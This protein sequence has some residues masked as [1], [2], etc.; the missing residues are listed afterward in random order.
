MALSEARKKANKKWDSE[1]LATFTIKIRK[2]KA[3]LFRQAAAADGKT[4][5]EILRKCIYDYLQ[6]NK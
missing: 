6:E 1:N 3:D 4:P 5:G 2:D